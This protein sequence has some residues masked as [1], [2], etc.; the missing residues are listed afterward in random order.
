M[1]TVRVDYLESNN[2]TELERILGSLDGAGFEI[3]SIIP[4]VNGLFL[5]GN[6]DSINGQVNSSTCTVVLSKHS[7]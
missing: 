6:N 5:N 4:D 2:R 3:I 7:E 1:T